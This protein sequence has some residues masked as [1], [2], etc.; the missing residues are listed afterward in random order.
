[1][2][3]KL[4]LYILSFLLFSCEKVLPI[5]TY[6]AK[7]MTLSAQLDTDSKVIV[8]LYETA[9][10]SDSLTLNYITDANVELY[11]NGNKISTLAFVR[12]NF[13]NQVGYYMDT[14]IQIKP[15]N[16]YTIKATHLN[17][18]NITAT[19]TVPALTTVTNTS[20]SGLPLYILNADSTYGQ[21]QFTIV[22]DANKHNTYIIYP[23]YYYSRYY[24]I[25]AT[26]SFL[27]WN[28]GYAQTCSINGMH[29]NNNF[30]FNKIDD[31]I[32]NGQSKQFTLDISK[33][34]DYDTS[35]I[36]A[37]VGVSVRQYSASFYLE[38][39][40]KRQYYAL[41]SNKIYDVPFWFYTNVIGGFGLLSCT[42]NNHQ[43]IAKIK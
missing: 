15:E 36:E 27:Q 37:Y 43:I 5:H 31:A 16:I 17:F 26:D 14:S 28:T 25:N 30:D 9:L 3:N 1:M 21:L 35:I 32:F 4:L 41:L 11:E 29:S 33:L 40:S 10:P 8:Q 2:K 19:D 39:E 7:Q 23:F 24:K 20:I 38:K 13:N 34:Y 42:S 12:D 18:P 6:I 22:D